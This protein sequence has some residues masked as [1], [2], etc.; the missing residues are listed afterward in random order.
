VKEVSESEKSC[1]DVEHKMFERRLQVD[2]RKH[3]F[4]EFLI[5]SRGVPRGKFEILKQKL[6]GAEEKRER[7]VEKGKS[8]KFHAIRV[9]TKFRRDEITRTV[10]IPISQQ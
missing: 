1:D 6:E 3:F 10:E 8:R 9:D 7:W 4:L 2:L 5:V